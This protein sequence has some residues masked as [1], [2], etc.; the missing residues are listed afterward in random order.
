M[1]SRTQCV[2]IRTCALLISILIVNGLS[3][4]GTPATPVDEHS[5]LL[6]KPQQE[7]PVAQRDPGDLVDF[8]A[9]LAAGGDYLRHAQADIT[10]D[11]AGNGDP[12][13]DPEDGGWDWVLTDPNFVHSASSSPTNIYGATAQGLLRAYIA[14]SDAGL[15]TALADCATGMLADPDIDSGADMIFLMN[16]NDLPSV[17]GTTYM[18]A[19]RA[20]YD[21]KI[22]VY[23]TAQALAEYIRDARNGQGY[24][25]GI[26]AWDI[27]AWVVSAAMLDDRYP[28]NGYDADASAMAEVVYQDSFNDNPGY[29]DIIDDQGFDPTY[30]DTNFW[31]YNLGITGLIDSF[32]YAGV[33]TAEIPGLVT[34]L[35]AGQH[36]DGGM[37]DAYGVNPDN[38]D[39]QTTAYSVLTLVALDQVTHQDAINRMAYWI[40]AWQ[41]GA[42]GAWI[43]GSGN[44]Y[45]EIG[46]ECT[47]ALSYGMSPTAVLVDD[48]FGDQADVD[49]YNAANSTSYVFGYD[50]FGTIQNGIDGVTT[51]GTVNVLLGT[52]AETVAIGTGFSGGTLVGEI[53]SLP[54]VTG[55]MTLAAGTSG[56]TVQNLHFTGVGASNT[57]IRMLG[58]VTDL[59][60]DNCIVDGELVSGRHGFGG[61]QL[62]GDATIM[63][64]EFKDVLGWSLFESRSGSGG[65]GSPLDVIIFSDNEINNCNGSVVFRGDETNPPTSYTNSVTISGNTWQTIGGNGGEQ[66]QHWAAF[67]VN[68]AQDVDIFDNTVDDVGEGQWGEGEAAQLWSITD[69]D[70]HDNS[71]TNCFQ[72]IWLAYVDYVSAG[73]I[74]NNTISGNTEYGLLVGAGAT[75][76]ALDASCNWWGDIDGPNDPPGNPS[77]GNDAVG[78]VMYWPWLDGPG[79]TCDLYSDNNVSAE[80]PLDCLTPTNTCVTVPVVFNR[81]DTTPSRGVSVTFQLSSELVLCTPDMYTDVTMA[82]GVGSWS[83]GFTNIHHE[84]IDNGGGSYTVDRFIIGMPCGPTNGGDLFYID[85]AKA[86]GVVT[87]ATGTVTVT[88]VLV[89]DC[90]NVTLAGMPGAPA[91]VSI[92]LTNP[93]T[94]ADLA[95]TQVKTGNDSNGTTKIDLAWTAPG[96]DADYIEI[97]RKGFGDYPEYDDGTGAVPTAPVSIANGW[98]LVTTLAATATSYV[99]EPA[100]RDFWYYAA[101]VTDTCDNV[102]DASAITGGTLNYHLGDFHDGATPG[103]GDN[104]VNMSDMSHFGNNYGI[105]LADPP[106]DPL[107]YLDVG[108]TSDYYVNALPTTDNRVQFE[109]LMMVAINFNQVS[110]LAPPTAAAHNEIAINVGAPGEVGSSFEVQIFMAGDGQV[111]GLSVPLSWKSDIVEPIG[112]QGGEL[113]EQQGGVHML[114]SPQPGTV[115]AAVFG[116]RAGISGEGLLAVVSFR[117]LSAGDPGIAP[118]EIIARSSENLELPIAGTVTT[119]TPDALVEHT[120]LHNAVPNPF[121]PSTEISFALAKDG[122]VTLRLYTLRGRLVRTLVNEEKTAGSHAMIWDGTDDAGQRVA[123]GTYLLRLVATDRVQSRQITLIK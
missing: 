51:G 122:P 121:N 32:N 107:A 25:N 42:S 85:V 46:G 6:L 57:I 29:F 23:G 87:D 95:A 83:E 24:P 84:I 5:D 8:A 89:R 62:E 117:V 80:D 90:M 15:A 99:D 34:I 36:S 97:F 111:Q 7:N 116:D 45:P 3:L 20:K 112:M 27:A 82:T 68:R 18:D 100:T 120:E 59:T 72:G 108:P 43:Y 47:A 4:A 114:L 81:V 66:G 1:F 58:G 67:E 73:T 110:K 2:V 101:Y 55:G 105:T 37:D 64:C 115:D 40:G 30:S 113:L 48:D 71:F 86:S 78:D 49:I 38:E 9:A 60:L 75:A 41:D 61:G 44:H 52:Y 26:I 92:D 70:V 53:G 19:A 11:N 76:G 50:A 17:G 96:G 79:G 74:S 10:E 12:D 109:D 54:L 28:G 16:Y 69:L 91:T 31:W 94:L 106:P 65:G 33:H 93:A 123:S 21:A 56:V 13:A 102:S 103:Q 14:S 88:D 77:A 119:S 98:T 63:N 39:W 118:G 22:V 104:L 35:L